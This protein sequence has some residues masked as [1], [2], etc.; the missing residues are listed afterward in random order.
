VAI[1]TQSH[2]WQRTAAPVA[3]ARTD[4]IWFVDAERGWAVNSNGHILHTQDGGAHWD[5]QFAVPGA[6]LRCVGF[7]DDRVGWVGTLALSRRL[8][9]TV[10]GGTTWALVDT[11]PHAAPPAICGLSVVDA[12]VVFAAGTNFPDKP[13]GVVKTLDAGVTW[14]VIDMADHATLLVD[15]FFRDALTGWVVGGKADVPDPSR[16]DVVPVVLHTRDGGQTWVNQL[17]AI[18]SNLPHGEWGWKIHF[19]DDEVGFVSLENFAAGAVLKTLDGGQTWERLPVDDAQ[20]NANLEGIGFVDDLHGWAGGWGDA[21]FSGGFT[22]ETQ[23]GG[24][25][26][27]N[28]NGVGKFLNRFRVIRDPELVAYAS[29]DTVYKYAAAPDAAPPPA[30]GDA[31]PIETTRLPLVIPV[32]APEGA[33]AVRVDVW[34]RFGRHLATPTKDPTSAETRHDVVWSGQT[35]DGE[36]VGPGI[37]LYRVTVDDR[38]ESRAVMIGG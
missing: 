20:G 21:Q 33:N 13:V 4:D 34:D 26:W 17:A 23:D 6:Y 3:S 2:M 11:L 9:R 18:S 37:Y 19:V 16:S 12:Q 1:A 27:Q 25:T 5:R 30:N 29:G 8:F 14:M 36:Q 28:A 31:E 35:D 38:S 24:H 32:D 15:V 7:A 10:D 22:S